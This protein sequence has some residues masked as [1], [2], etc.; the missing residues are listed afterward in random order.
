MD[1]QP[2]GREGGV[3]VVVVG[4]GVTEE[5]GSYDSQ[6][7][8]WPVVKPMDW[9]WNWQRVFSWSLSI[10]HKHGKSYPT[11]QP[12]SPPSYTYPPPSYPAAT[13]TSLCRWPICWVNSAK[14]TY[15]ML[16]LQLPAAAA[17]AAMC[18]TRSAEECCW[19][20]QLLQ[21]QWGRVM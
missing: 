15:G 1:T 19:Q 7:K 21:L 13:E 20:Q 16:L 2:G 17:T 10:N 4:G 5:V 11:V 18:S 9:R 6:A 3:V 14:E 8:A 12:P